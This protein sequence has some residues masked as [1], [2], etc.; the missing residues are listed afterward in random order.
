MASYRIVVKPSV[1]KD[2]K[3]IPQKTRQRIIATIE[4]LG[5]DPLPVGVKKLE[6]S[7]RT[8]RVRVGDYRIIYEFEKTAKTITIQYVRHRSIAYR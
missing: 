4:S 7:E 3:P 2:L 6:G 8:Y 5:S 1:G